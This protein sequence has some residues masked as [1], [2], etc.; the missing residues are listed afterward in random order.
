MPLKIC[1]YAISKNESKFI[2]RFC[3]SAKTADLIVIADTG[4]TD[5]TIEIAKSYFNTTVY[6]INVIPWRFDHARTIALSLVPENI[7]ICIALDIDEIL[8]DNWRT[9]VET[10]WTTGNNVNLLAYQYDWGD[11]IK[12]MSLKIH[13][14]HGWIWK[15][16][17]HE[18][19]FPDP[20]T[21]AIMARTDL[22][23]IK[24]MRDPTKS[25]QSYLDLMAA[26][27][28]DT[29]NNAKIRFYYARELRAQNKIDECITELE[30]LLNMSSNL[31]PNELC[32]AY[33]SLANCYDQ[34]LYLDR[35]KTIANYKKAIEISVNLGNLRR[36]PWVEYAE[37]CY[38]A[39]EWEECMVAAKQALNIKS[40]SIG[41]QYFGEQTCEERA[42]ILVNK[43]LSQTRDNEVVHSKT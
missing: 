41:F 16:M 6:S 21:K 1:V 3:E 36:E 13:S 18:V 15:N 37:S 32:N 29:P 31:E 35:S 26:N 8:V 12:Y 25:R 24:Q 42:M 4:S 10:L 20:R 5:N 2:Q 19:V 14:R 28:K 30:I 39:D 27:L 34:I 38:N 43:V 33:L 23:L 11:S 22:V 7:D 9:I 17:C 40:I